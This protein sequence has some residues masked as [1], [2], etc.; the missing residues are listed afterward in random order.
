MSKVQQRAVPPRTKLVALS[1]PVVDRFGSVHGWRGE[2][3]LLS[4]V[5]AAGI[6]GWLNEEILPTPKSFTLVSEMSLGEVLD[7]VYSAC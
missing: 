6:V 5:H 4:N 1:E 3:T 7:Q 2:S